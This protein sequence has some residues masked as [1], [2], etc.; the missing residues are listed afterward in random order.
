MNIIV[1]ASKNANFGNP[2]IVKIYQLRSEVNFKKV[3]LE[4]FWDN[5]QIIPVDDITHKPIEI[6]LYPQDAKRIQDL[7]IHDE[8]VFLAAA[9]NFYN[10]DKDRWRY[11]YD[12][13]KHKDKSVLVAIFENKVIIGK[14]EQ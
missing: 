13:S 9:A 2:V 8:T 5:D 1:K 7:N 12:I 4:A 10:P 3:T 11:I 6:L 14:Y